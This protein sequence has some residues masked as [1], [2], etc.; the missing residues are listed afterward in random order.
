MFSPEK[1][2]AAWIEKQA[3][4]MGCNPI[5]LERCVHALTLLG[6]LAESGLSFTFK[7]GTSLL[8][9][10]K[11]IQR[12]SIDIDIV[13]REKPED[14][15]K[16]ITQIGSN[17]R[18]LRWEEDDRE[19]RDLPN[20][21]HYKF[22]FRSV[23]GN[24]PELTILLDVVEEGRN[25]HQLVRL[26]IKT[27]FIIPEREVQVQLPT[28]ESLL[29][30][31]LTAFAPK[32]IGVPLYDPE[33]KPGE[34]MQVAKQLFDV[35]SLFEVVRDFGQVAKT[36]GETHA[37]ENE[38]RGGKYSL[39]TVLRDTYDACL[40]LTAVNTRVAGK[41]PDGPVLY[42]GFQNMRG[43]YVGKDIKHEDV[44]KLAARAALL[45]AS[46]R[47]KSLLEFPACRYTGSADQIAALRTVTFN[48]TAFDWLDGVKAVNPEAYYYWHRAIQLDQ[49]RPA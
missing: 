30:D 2:T 3:K 47:A 40:A 1:Y 9:H 18:F 41:Y 6:N 49:P 15:R 36:Y 8:L 12:L 17:P 34:L 23:L 46:I 39:E 45:A 33:G 37:L 38:Y 29:G 7:G 32:T 4:A 11:E 43:H 31:K 20:R 22:Y 44:R 10:L 26:P 24:K 14:V 27:A 19:H 28:L 42:R 35:G 5:I 25:H 48:R 16:E 21:R 13:C